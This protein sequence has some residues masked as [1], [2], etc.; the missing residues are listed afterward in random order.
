MREWCSHSLSNVLKVKVSIIAPHE[1]RK[2][3]EEFRQRGMDIHKVLRL[4]VF[5]CEFAEMDFIEP[6][7]MNMPSVVNI[8]KTLTRHNNKAH[9]HNT[10]W[11]R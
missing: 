10:I 6:E 2:C 1:T 8:M 3:N 7:H 5:R 4:D 9:L 11:L